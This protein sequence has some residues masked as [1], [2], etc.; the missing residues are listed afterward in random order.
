MVDYGGYIKVAMTQ[1]FNKHYGCLYAAAQTGTSIPTQEH[2]S[3]N[4]RV[5]MRPAWNI[6]QSHDTLA[7]SNDVRLEIHIV[8]WF[9]CHLVRIRVKA[10]KNCNSGLWH[11]RDDSSEMGGPV[12][13]RAMHCSHGSHQGL[14]WNGGAQTMTYRQGGRFMPK[15]E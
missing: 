2:R 15:S 6:K 8:M 11:Q 12:C 7:W 1:S 10:E 4:N 13:V 14:T 9:S 5:T 3:I